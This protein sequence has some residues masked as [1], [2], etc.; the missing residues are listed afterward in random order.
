VAHNSE[1]ARWLN[2][3]TN[4]GTAPVD[5]TITLRGQFGAGDDTLVTATSSGDSS[6]GA[7]DLWFTTAQQVLRGTFSTIPKVG[8]VVQG[9]GA[10][11]P[12][13]SAGINGSGTAA[14]TYRPTIAPGA[15]AIVMTFAT[16]QGSSKQAK[17]VSENLIELP[18]EAIACLTQ[19]ELGQIVNF[20]PITEPELKKASITLEFKEKKVDKDLVKWKGRITIGAGL[21]LAGMLVTVDVGGAIR[22]LILDEKGRGNDGAGSKFN[23][24][25]KL[26]KNGLTKVDTVKF[27]FKLRGDFKTPLAEYGLVDGTVSDVPLTVPVT[28]TVGGKSYGTERAFTY[29][30]K[31]GKTGKAK[32]VL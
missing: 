3:V 14:V 27:S 11:S 17:K 2:I 32:V 22:S 21:S 25:A 20:A 23:L 30:A 19:A 13:T 1:F 29:S 7:A 28:F 5:V 26:D 10:V 18:S 16:V 24:R 15:S 4:T 9:A 8:F 12:A 31:Q 6:I